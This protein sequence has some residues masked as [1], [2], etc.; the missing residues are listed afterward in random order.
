MKQQ[1]LRNGNEVGPAKAGPTYYFRGR[2]IMRVPTRRVVFA[3]ITAIAIVAAAPF[4]V[5]PIAQSGR[6]AVVTRDLAVA[7]PESVGVSSERL[8]RLEAAMKKSV[9]DKQLAGVVTLLARHGK[10]AY[11]NA[12]GLKDV[13]KPDPIQKD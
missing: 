8:H 2:E 6:T 9:D 12:V 11:F 10:V 4:S 1:R 13:R 5:R 7:P 3:S